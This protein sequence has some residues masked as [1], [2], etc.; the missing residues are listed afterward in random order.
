M[1]SKQFL[2]A[3]LAVGAAR[4][5]NLTSVLAGNSNLTA[6]TTLLSGSPDLAGALSNAT[7]IT[8]LAPSNEALGALNSSGLL[9]SSSQQGLIQALLNYH[10]LLGV[11]NASNITETPAFPAT[12]LNDTAYTNVTGGQVVECRVVD[13]EVTVI[14]GLKNNVSVT[15]AVS[16]LIQL[17]LDIS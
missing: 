8:L 10:V 3:A 4:A 2:G 15:Q 6:L 13:D 11:F 1:H 12:L 7:N 17:V 9:S 14:S 5:Q 16:S